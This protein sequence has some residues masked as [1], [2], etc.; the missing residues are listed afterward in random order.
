MATETVTLRFQ[1]DSRDAVRAARALDDALRGIST[2]ANRVEK[3]A[4]GAFD[5]LTKGGRQAVQ[6]ASRVERSL[7]EVDRAAERTKKELRQAFDAKGDNSVQAARSLGKA[8]Q[9]V[10]REA[11][12]TRKDLSRAFD[13]AD[14]DK[15]VRESRRAERALKDVGDA[16]DRVRG[17]LRSALTSGG[18]ALAGVLGGAAII[19][20]IRKTITAASDLNE[21]IDKTKVVF[22]QSS[23]AVLSWSKTTATAMGLSQRAALGAAGAFGNMFR[24]MGLG[25]QEAADM[26][27]RMVQLAADMASFSNEDPTEML[28][29]LR[30][31]LA[32]EAEPLRRF[33]VLLSESK[34]Q[35]EAVRMG[36][37]RKGEALTESQ[38]VLARY[39]II[40]RET[41]IQ[42]GNFEKT[43]GGLANQQ[44]ILRAQIENASAAIGRV[45]LPVL[46]PLVKR[47]NEWLQQTI[48]SGEAQRKIRGLVKQASEV[49]RTAAGIMQRAAGAARTF[50]D[51]VGGWGNAF[52][53]V[54]SGVIAVKLLKIAGALQQIGGVSRTAAI[55]NVA[56]DIT[57][58]G[59]GADGSLKKVGRLRGALVGLGRIGAIAILVELLINKNEIDSWMKRHGL[60]W[61]N[62]GLIQIVADII[63]RPSRDTEAGAA[64]RQARIGTAPRPVLSPTGPPR[65]RSVPHAEPTPRTVKEN[66]TNQRTLLRDYGTFLTQY[67]RLTQLVGRVPEETQPWLRRNLAKLNQLLAQ[68]VNDSTKQRA[69]TLL[70]NLRRVINSEL[71]RV[72]ARDDVNHLRAR[73]RF[74][75]NHL[76][77]LP[78]AVR[79]RLRREIGTLRGLLSGVVSADE[80]Q[81][82]GEMLDRYGNAL[83]AGFARAAAKARQAAAKA[84]FGDLLKKTLRDGRF[85]DAE[86]ASLSQQAERV[87][88]AV[89][90][91]LEKAI[92]AVA[93]ARTRFQ[94]AAQKFKD[95]VLEL[96]RQKVVGKFDVGI[97]LGEVT[98]NTTVAQRTLEQGTAALGRFAAAGLKSADRRVY[99][100]VQEWIT[101]TQGYYEALA[102]GNAAK[103]KEAAVRLGNAT[104]T[105]GALQDTELSNVGQQILNAGTKVTGALETIGQNN[106]DAA[107]KSWDDL[108]AEEEKKVDAYVT[109]VIGLLDSG[110]IS[111]S[112]AMTRIRKELK[113]YGISPAD[114]DKVITG[115][116]GSGLRSATTKL[117]QAIGR[118]TKKLGK[119][120]TIKATV[121]AKATGEDK[122]K[123]LRTAINGVKPKQVTVGAKTGAAVTAIKK[124]GQT[125]GALRGKTITVKV[126]TSQSRVAPR[127]A[128]TGGLVVDGGIQAP[129]PLRYQMGG[130]S[131]FVPGVGS[132]DT[133]SALLTP[134]ELILN[135]AQQ[136]NLAGQ[137]QGGNVIHNTFH[138]QSNDPDV[139]GRTVVRYLERFAARNGRLPGR[140]SFQGG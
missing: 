73:L 54:L 136:T 108:S 9:A 70:G 21:E 40:L 69:R 128:A 140:L 51:V 32:G 104:A 114:I 125:I 121:A 92:Q 119:N 132:R 80:A 66:R 138:I 22:G 65:G 43:S 8:L 86:L 42:Q 20:G 41:G 75:Q 45:L 71:E 38:K 16:G 67:R 44:R 46:I 18:A 15:T 76:N 78:P 95:A 4:R 122:V 89:G 23:G 11:E 127:G 130:L 28:D 24:A 82:A 103:I 112:T 137:L 19:G 115:A 1:G 109:K 133:V 107:K 68:P 34:V 98:L 49:I 99:N 63:P 93:G 17:R 52:K 100:A 84:K 7:R 61:A 96:F 39:S 27:R 5:P 29:K 36:L 50:A 105:I 60:G 72:A 2:E 90:A 113:K 26:S 110:K 79:N 48:K 91:G 97:E 35:L 87:G 126:L 81:K 120:I 12:K 118:L 53:L 124:L 88:G 33:G 10:D 13:S 14:A 58:V 94:T 37:V 123:T 111:F 57:A 64:G 134:G 74:L 106:V 85:T 3:S 25:Q 131:G 116:A 59:T 6:A 102:T 47:L 62:K 77:V 83:R 55:S 101:A 31:G 56:A 117:T 139:V 135:R 129:P 30:S